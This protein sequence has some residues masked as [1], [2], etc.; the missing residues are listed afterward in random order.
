MDNK[1][2]DIFHILLAGYCLIWL[3][4]GLFD[5]LSFLP[6]FSVYIVFILWLLIAVTKCK[7]FIS[8]VVSQAWPLYLLFII[9]FIMNFKNPSQFLTSNITTLMYVC[10]VHMIFLYYWNFS[11]VQSRKVLFIILAL[12]IALISLKTFV[13]LL[14]YPNV[15]RYLSA[16]I[17]RYEEIIKNQSLLGLSTVA[18]SQL[19]AV[20]SYGF[21]NAFL[22]VQLVLASAACSLFVRQRR[23][24]ALII[25]VFS[26]ILSYKASFFIILILGIVA[27]LAILLLRNKSQNGSVVFLIIAFIVF[28]LLS[29]TGVL[30]FWISFIANNIDNSTI[31]ERL[32]ELSS[33]LSGNWEGGDGDLGSRFMLYGRSIMNFFNHPFTGSLFVSISGNIGG[34]STGFDFL[35][36][37]GIFGAT[38]FLFIHNINLSIKKKIPQKQ[39]R[40]FIIGKVCFIILMF[41]NSILAAPIFIA[42]MIF[43][44]FGLEYVSIASKDRRNGTGEEIV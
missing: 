38:L 25:L 27:I 35:G 43:L 2:I 11:N 42:Y 39:Y 15:A 20:G 9:N 21:F 13:I 6:R 22:F 34:H 26:L 3:Y 30:S 37:Y 14:E 7:S 44:P 23:M 41:V 18:V 36:V 8:N 32:M 12:N 33:F 17:A 24:I 5:F 19:K 31:S 10:V 29:S 28:V 40:I 4:G 1:K 16:G